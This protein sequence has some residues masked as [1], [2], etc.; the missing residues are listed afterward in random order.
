MTQSN[1]PFRSFP[2]VI[3]VVFSV[4]F[5]G[6][7]AIIPLCRRTVFVIFVTL[8]MKMF[9]TYANSIHVENFELLLH[10]SAR[11]LIDKGIKVCATAKY[12]KRCAKLV[13]TSQN[14]TCNQQ[15][16]RPARTERSDDENI[17]KYPKL[18]KSL[19]FFFTLILLFLICF[20]CASS[21]EFYHKIRTFPCKY[22]RFRKY[23]RLE[24]FLLCCVLIE[25]VKR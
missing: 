15:N 3:T 25:V 12:H 21:L 24:V 2:F 8:K 6:D 11:F 14:V 9:E 4:G 19:I 22:L 23:S 20:S 17:K 13:V 10:L 7:N 16:L 5:V 1:Y 18:Y